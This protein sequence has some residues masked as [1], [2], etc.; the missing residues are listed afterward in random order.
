MWQQEAATIAAAERRISWHQPSLHEQPLVPIEARD[1]V[2]EGDESLLVSM[3]ESNEEMTI[4]GGR[5]R[6]LVLHKL[7]E[8]VLTGETADDVATLKARA[9]ELIAQLGLPD[10]EDAATGL[11]SREM[12]TA[13]Q[14]TLQLR[15]I[16]ELRPRL[17]PEFRVYAASV[18]GQ[19]TSL[20]AGIADA[21]AYEGG[22]I[23]TVVDWKSD[24]NPTP[25]DIEMYRSQVRDYLKATG[26]VLGLIVFVTS[27]R[28]E[29]VQSA[30]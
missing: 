4:Q 11:S 22:Y 25:A 1:E 13:L 15:E 21:V 18:S 3:P 28:I 29:Q 19:T 30:A 9:S 16:A 20:T 14:R 10:A 6:G 7:M 26:A 8:E 12:A 2:F 27:G 17:L 5:E 23:Q 24:V